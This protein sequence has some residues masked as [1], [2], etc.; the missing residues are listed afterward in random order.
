[1]GSVVDPSP[2]HFVADYYESGDLFGQY[3][4]TLYSILLMVI[5]S[6]MGTIGAVQVFFPINKFIHELSF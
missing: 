6:E 3:A 5:G 2:N 1:M 4:Y